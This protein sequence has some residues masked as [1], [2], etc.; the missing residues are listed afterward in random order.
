MK[1]TFCLCLIVIAVLSAGAAAQG[2][3]QITLPAMPA[4]D[5]TEPPLETVDRVLTL[6]AGERGVLE[7]SQS[8]R[9]ETVGPGV[10]LLFGKTRK[11]PQ[12]SAEELAQLRRPLHN[13]LLTN[14]ATYQGRPIRIDGYVY[15]VKPR[16]A[17]KTIPASVELPAGTTVWMIT[18]YDGQSEHQKGILIYSLVDPTPLLPRPIR[19]E[20][21]NLQIH[22]PEDNPRQTY[23]EFAGV[24]VKTFYDKEEGNPDSDAPKV[25]RDFPLIITWQVAKPEGTAKG[26]SPFSPMIWLVVFAI[27]TMLVA[28]IFLWRKIH[29][30]RVATDMNPEFRWQ[31]RYTPFRDTE[32][33]DL[34]NDDRNDADHIDP[35]LRAAAEALK[36]AAAA[37]DVDTSEEPRHD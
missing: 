32:L 20:P 11:L 4:L 17:G 29:R 15:S 2:P 23:L 10:N 33:D 28:F 9:Q 22:N 7:V 25:S 18:M 21:D 36:K 6:S 3:V 24:L 19:I 5:R 35:E 8:R 16:I 13:S 26:E 30:L 34:A 1:R 14:T 37:E 12:L 31:G 27:I